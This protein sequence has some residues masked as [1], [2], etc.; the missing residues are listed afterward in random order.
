MAG[1][2][3]G[4]ARSILSLPVQMYVRSVCRR[5]GPARGKLVGWS[6]LRP[7]EETGDERPRL[8]LDRAAATKDQGRLEVRWATEPDD[9]PRGA[10]DYRVAIM[11]GEE[12]LAEQTVSH[13][14]V[15][16]QR[17]VFSIEYFDHLGSDAKFEASVHISAI[18]ATD[19]PAVQSEE[20]VLEFGEAEGKSTA[21]SGK[22][23]RSLIDGASRF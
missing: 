8:V 20:F 4:F 10:V 7:T 1:Q 5:G 19:V 23:E 21:V 9:L 17:A 16:P 11:A 22:V 15:N 2:T 12:E 18:G 13:K 6:G 3:S 14:E